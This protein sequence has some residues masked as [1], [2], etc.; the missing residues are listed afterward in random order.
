MFGWLSDYTHEILLWTRAFL[1]FLEDIAQLREED[2]S[3]SAMHN[4]LK[5]YGIEECP[6]HIWD[7][8]AERFPDLLDEVN[9][10]RIRIFNDG[11]HPDSGE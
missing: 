9:D 2:Y 10:V 1:E 6:Q 11:K 7:A 5:E 4:L 3:W 8:L